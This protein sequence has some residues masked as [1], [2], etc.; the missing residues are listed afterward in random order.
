MPVDTLF[1]LFS[2]TTKFWFVQA[3]FAFSTIFL[4]TAFT[5]SAL[6][7]FSTYENFVTYK[8]NDFYYA[9]HAYMVVT[10]PERVEFEAVLSPAA[11]FS[12]TF[13]SSNSFY[14]IEHVLGAG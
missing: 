7:L 4:I 14:I 2:W 6:F 3:E 10:L 5:P 8:H 12:F 11:A 9:R 13:C 1:L